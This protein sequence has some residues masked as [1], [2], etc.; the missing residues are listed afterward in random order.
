M[1]IDV[2]DDLG[3]ALLS[4]FLGGPP[5][6]LKEARWVERDE[7]LD[8]DFALILVDEEGRDHRKFACHDACSTR[9]SAYY[10]LNVA[11]LPPVAA[12]V[13][14]AN[15]LQAA[16]DFGCQLAENCA[17]PLYKI[18]SAEDCGGMLD[19][20][21]VAVKQAQ[22][23]MPTNGAAQGAA[24]VSMPLSGSALP[25]AISGLRTLNP[26]P[27]SAAPF[28]QGSTKVSSYDVL[29]A[30][31]D[32]WHELD[33]Y[34][35]RE[36][37]LWLRQSGSQEGLDLPEKIAA[38]AGDS[39]SPD[40][41]A[42]IRVRRHRV[43]E[44]MAEEYD[45]LE[46]VAQFLVPDLVVDALYQLDEAAGLLLKHGETLPD[47]VRSVFS[48]PKEAAWSW[49]HGDIL[50]NEHQ[51]GDFAMRNSLEKKMEAIF[52][53]ELAMKFRKDPVGTF[54]AMPVGQK[55]IVARMATQSGIHNDGGGPWGY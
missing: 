20:R 30:C 12:K 36:A 50:V 29:R 39:L 13:A 10:L 16:A 33:P 54:K 43:T 46:K 49:T 19:E 44:E 45:R 24:R 27:M 52:T 6:F 14:A 31:V 53:E 18:A 37:A 22:M 4:E 23:P 26:A 51:L 25:P 11:E 1:T 47:P 40:F 9:V 28:A 8:R 2:H 5:E 7:L 55:M 17:T 34:Q 21:L 32:E 42:A 38:Y 41:P 48:M 3:E 35:R 15:I